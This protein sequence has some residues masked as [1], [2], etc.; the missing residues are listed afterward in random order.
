MEIFA[1]TLGTA[2][3]YWIGNKL[4]NTL[5]LL[6]YHRNFLTESKYLN[7]YDIM[8]DEFYFKMLP[9]SSLGGNKKYFDYLKL[10]QDKRPKAY[11]TY[12]SIIDESAKNFFFLVALMVIFPSIMFYS[13]WYLY[14][15]P[16]LIVTIGH[17]VY[18]RIV[19][20]YNLDFFII[21][22]MN[23]VLTIKI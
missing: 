5:F 17:I 10:R 23:T 11:K 8:D 7:L 21:S 22:A 13:I 4:S 15:I 20:N 9:K 19:K 6:Y 12:R 14:F 1:L 16:V 2:I 18:K 3:G